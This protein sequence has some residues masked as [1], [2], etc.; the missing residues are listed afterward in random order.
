[1]VFGYLRGGVVPLRIL[2]PEFELLILVHE[3]FFL[4][5]KDVNSVGR[6]EALYLVLRIAV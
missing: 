6:C 1:V 4:R 3:W 5:E 2:D